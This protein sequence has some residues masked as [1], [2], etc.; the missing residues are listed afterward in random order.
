MPHTPCANRK[1]LA[2]HA[3]KERRHMSRTRFVVALMLGMAVVLSLLHPALAQSSP[4]V[5]FSGTGSGSFYS[6]TK[7]FGFWILFRGHSLNPF[8]CGCN[9]TLVFCSLCVHRSL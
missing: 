3:Q 5:V 4:Q 8:F 2:L 9:V 6:T 1:D 7:P